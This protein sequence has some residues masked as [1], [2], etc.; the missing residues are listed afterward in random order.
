MGGVLLLVLGLF[1]SGSGT[2]AARLLSRLF[3][4]HQTFGQTCAVIG[5]VLLAVALGSTVFFLGLQALKSS[6]PPWR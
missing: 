1:I 3:P 4:A 2:F 6:R 5:V